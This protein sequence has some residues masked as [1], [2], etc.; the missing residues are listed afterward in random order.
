M[1]IYRVGWLAKLLALITMGFLMLPL[2]A[3]IPVSFTG[4]RYLS[5]PEGD[6]SLRHYITLFHSSE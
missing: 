4:K 5:M 2:A 1:N 3:V 6:W